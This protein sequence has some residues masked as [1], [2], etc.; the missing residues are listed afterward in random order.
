MTQP[1]MEEG[2]WAVLRNGEVTG[3]LMP[4]QGPNDPWPFCVDY[5]D[6]AAFD[7]R[8]VACTGTY[9]Q[10]CRPDLNIIATFPTRAEAEA[11]TPGQPVPVVSDAPAVDWEQRRWEAA[12]ENM[13]AVMCA[14]LKKSQYPEYHWFVRAAELSALAADALIAALKG[15]TK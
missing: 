11:Y 4:N 2:R 8:G 5:R 3:P 9:P 12:K 13:A 7:K 10:D 1:I 14:N 6:W 15:E